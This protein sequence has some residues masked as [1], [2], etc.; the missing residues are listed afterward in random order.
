MCLTL[1]PLDTDDE[2]EDDDDDDE[3]DDYEDEDEDEDEGE[4]DDH[5]DHDDYDDYDYEEDA[6]ETPFIIPSGQS[7]FTDEEFALLQENLFPTYH[8]DTSI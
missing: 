7:L 8:T 3:D 5:D 1:S 6:D 2:S 4:D